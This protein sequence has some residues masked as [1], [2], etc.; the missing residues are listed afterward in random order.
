MKIEFYLHERLIFSTPN[1]V[2]SV[3]GGCIIVGAVPAYPQAMF[4]YCLKPGEYAKI[5][6]ADSL[7]AVKVNE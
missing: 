7:T 4:I 1:S 2:L 5:T 6:T 3:E